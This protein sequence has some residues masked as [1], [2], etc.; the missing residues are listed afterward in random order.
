[1]AE[2]INF[3]VS[4]E[5]SA[6]INHIV[7]MLSIKKG[8]RVS[9]AEFMRDITE[10]SINQYE[11]MLAINLSVHINQHQPKTDQRDKAPA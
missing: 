9:I 8:R 3:R 7:L 5:T 6:R 1:M 2:S 11:T 4:K 10:A